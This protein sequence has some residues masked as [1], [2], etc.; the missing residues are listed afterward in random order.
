[1]PPRPRDPRPGFIDP[2]FRQRRI[3]VRRLEGRRRLRILL[4]LA[5]FVGVALVG[6]GVSRSPLLDAD[7]VRI[8]GTV[9]TTAA[10]I[11]T[12][13]GPPPGAARTR[14]GGRA[15]DLLAAAQAMLPQVMQRVAGVV[16][17]EGAQVELRLRPEEVVRLG[18]H[19]QLAEKMLA[20]QA[21][22]AQVG[23]ARLAV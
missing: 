21:V 17:A 9:N 6:W 3:E 8:T 13:A 12:A 19:D 5:T 4:I 20:T 23:L 7:H 1:A 11:M 14:I 10:P 18:P 15:G 2:K 22:L 16:A